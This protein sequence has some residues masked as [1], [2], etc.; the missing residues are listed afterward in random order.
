[1][2]PRTRSTG[3]LAY[4]A[5]LRKSDEFARSAEEALARGD[6]NAA[7]STAVHA[8][9]N[10][11]DALTSFHAGLRSRGESH[12]DLLRLLSGLKIERKELD[13]NVAHLR[14]LPQLKT[15]AEYEEGLLGER[16]ARTACE[17]ARRIRAWVRGKVPTSP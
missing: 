2:A 15:T 11:T 1:M 3:P 8:A 4:R 5:Y 12:G 9:I 17:H 7:V 14:A 10:P 16:P 13:P 6:W